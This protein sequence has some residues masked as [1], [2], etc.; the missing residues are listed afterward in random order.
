MVTAMLAARARRGETISADRVC[1]V[2]GRNVSALRAGPA[3]WLVLASGFFEP[4]LYL[5]SIGLGVGAL[6]GELT[7]PDGRTVPYAA[8]VAPAM[9]AASAMSGAVAETAFN[10]FH[11]LKYSKTYDAVLATPV[12][13]VELALGELAWATARSCVYTGLFLGVMVALGLTGPGWALAAFPAAVLVGLAFGAAGM[14][15]STLIRGWQDFD[16]LNTALF[17]LVFF[18]G[19]FAPVQD[20]PAAAEVIIRLTPLYHA[21][22]LLRG[23]T[24]GALAAGLFGHVAYLLVM[25]VAGLVVGGR[26]LRLRLCG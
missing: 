7:L 17:A 24:T 21:V 5:L 3:Y 14:A 4:L 11:K 9:L 10:F 26:R 20:Y 25:T 18:S 2:A 15:V 19:T 23:L 12:R 1:A 13:P 16:L 22:E 8:F 6:V